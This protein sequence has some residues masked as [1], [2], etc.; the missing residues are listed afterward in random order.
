M[1][2]IDGE[3]AVTPS[4]LGIQEIRVGTGALVAANATVTVNYTGWFEDGK[5]FDAGSGL[6][7]SLSG[8]IEGWQEGLPGMRVGG[9]R[10]LI[11]PPELA[12]GKQ[13][14]GDVIPPNAT[15]IFDI[16]LVSVP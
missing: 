6:Q 13:G 12:Y 15:L 16:E 11:I 14:S 2:P 10:R 5:P 3:P 9:E 8:L 4:G 7:F 1:P